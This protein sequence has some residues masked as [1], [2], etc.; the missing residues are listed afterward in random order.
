LEN[1][2]ATSHNENV[3]AEKV[4][5]TERRLFTSALQ[6]GVTTID[7]LCFIPTSYRYTQH[8]QTFAFLAAASPPRISDDPKSAP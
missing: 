3:C 1:S 6:V 8:Y 5:V 7:K 2:P 4:K